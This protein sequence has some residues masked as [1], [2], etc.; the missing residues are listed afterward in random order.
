MRS[1]LILLCGFLF[2]V[3]AQGQTGNADNEISAQDKILLQEFWKD[4]T[5][6]VTR[7]D[8]AKL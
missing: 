6:A 7:N 1:I 2:S 8:K 4:F 3:Y 5:D